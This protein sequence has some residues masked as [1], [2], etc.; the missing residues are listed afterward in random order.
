[1][2]L[3]MSLILYARGE[4]GGE[5]PIERPGRKEALLYFLHTGRKRDGAVDGMPPTGRLSRLFEA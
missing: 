4:G 1:M 2:F 3:V 5:V